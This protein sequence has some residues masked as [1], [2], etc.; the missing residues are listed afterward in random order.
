MTRFDE[1]RQ[2]TLNGAYIAN[3]V[4]FSRQPSSPEMPTVFFISEPVTESQIN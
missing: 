3:P 4:R 1:A 2:I